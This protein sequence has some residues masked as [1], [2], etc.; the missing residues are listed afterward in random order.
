MKN[1]YILLIAILAVGALTVF[2]N[3]SDRDGTTHTE[4]SEK[5]NEAVGTN[6]VTIESYKYS[7]EKITVK[8]GT[9][10]TWEN[11][12]LAP[13]TVTV[14]E[15]EG[16]GPDS[17]LFGKGEKYSYTFNEAG[18]FPY[19]CKPHPYMKGEVVVIE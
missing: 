15:G 4:V 5:Q 1:K 7:P 14:E 18:T 3:F 11:L 10:V 17:E 8:K 9:T 19:Y 12:D 2:A 16:P 13:H 6:N